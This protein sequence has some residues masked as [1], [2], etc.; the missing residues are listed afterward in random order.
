MADAAEQVAALEAERFQAMIDK[1]VKRLGELLADDL[2]YTHSNA[3][4]D[5]K[6]SYLEAIASGKFDY[7]A[8]ERSEEAVRVY[9]D[10]ALVTGRAALTLGVAPKARSLDLRYLDVWV[11]AGE[12]W[13]MVAWQSTVVPA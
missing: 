3:S 12:A 4:I 10:T 11:R 2:V 5:T 13:R 9:G 7:R 6:D 8:A 1:N